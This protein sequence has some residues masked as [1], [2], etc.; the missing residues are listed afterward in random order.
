MAVALE[1]VAAEAEEGAG[2]GAVE[3][4]GF[5]EGELGFGTLET[6]FVDA[7]EFMRPARLASRPAFGVPRA[8]RWM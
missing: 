4:L 3:F 2:L 7:A 8:R 6:G 5:E 1:T